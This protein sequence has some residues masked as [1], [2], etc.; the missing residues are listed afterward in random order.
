MTTYPSTRRRTSRAAFTLIELLTVIAI[1]A[2][3]VAMTLGIVSFAQDKAAEERTR[4]G[5]AMIEAGLKRYKDKYG[6]YPVP[7]D[8]DGRGIG[9]AVAIYQALNDDG[10]D[11]LVNGSEP[12]DGRAGA[13][14]LMDLVSEGYVG[15]DGRDYFVKDGYDRPFQFRVFDPN[16]PDATRQKT[17]DLWSYGKDKE[18]DERN[19]AKW[20]KNW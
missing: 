4:S 14:R 2:I 18:K 6:E 1:L 7:V 17:Y 8:N 11:Y 3:L 19:E 5:L 20:I 10:D 12:S 13:E 16:N 15:T 9:G